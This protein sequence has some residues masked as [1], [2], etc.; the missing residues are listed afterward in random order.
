MGTKEVGGRKHRSV[1]SDLAAYALGSGEGEAS[2]FFGSLYE[3]QEE[4]TQ[5]LRRALERRAVA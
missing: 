3:E 1:N 5:C 4:G 2:W